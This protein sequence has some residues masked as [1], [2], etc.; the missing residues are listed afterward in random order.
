MQDE[1]KNLVSHSLAFLIRKRE[2]RIRQA[3]SGGGNL[4]KPAFGKNYEMF[5]HLAT[6]WTEWI[7]SISIAFLS[8]AKKKKEDGW[9]YPKG[10]VPQ[11][12]SFK[13]W[14]PGFSLWKHTVCC[15]HRSF[16]W[17]TS[18]LQRAELNWW[19]REGQS[20]EIHVLPSSDHVS[21]WRCLSVGPEL[22][23]RNVTN[24]PDVL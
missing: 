18:E 9:Q 16:S 13:G 20:L 2:R 15:S 11:F 6:V 7:R 8:C 14:Q 21:R 3:L 23:E 22:H 24:I 17:T 5:R 12:C 19:S 1:A 10:F 4:N